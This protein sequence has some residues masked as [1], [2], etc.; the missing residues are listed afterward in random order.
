M[1]IE[2]TVENEYFIE[3]NSRKYKKRNFRRDKKG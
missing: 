2:E 1:E 3:K